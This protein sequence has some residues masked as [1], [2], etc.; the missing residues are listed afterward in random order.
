MKV[1][2]ELKNPEYLTEMMEKHGAKEFGFEMK[3][4]FGNEL[5]L[6]RNNLYRHLDKQKMGRNKFVYR[7]YCAFMMDKFMLFMRDPYLLYIP[8]PQE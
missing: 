2:K 6:I 7:K 3:E 1:F 8:K 5:D 4:G